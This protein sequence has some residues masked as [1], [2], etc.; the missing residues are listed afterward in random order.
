MLEG[1]AGP[2]PFSSKW[3]EVLFEAFYFELQGYACMCLLES[4]SGLKSSLIKNE[5]PTKIR[6][7]GCFSQHWPSPCRELGSVFRLHCSTKPLW[8]V[9]EETNTGQIYKSKLCL[10]YK[11]NFQGKAEIWY[12]NVGRKCQPINKKLKFLLV[13]NFTDRSI[14][15]VL[16]PTLLVTTSFFF[17]LWQLRCS[18][19]Y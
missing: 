4:Q 2:L 10:T 14:F 7:W 16:F 9:S 13:Y 19:L 3:H 18:S 1:F 5:K 6:Q 17:V 12:K 15:A 11:C 8:G